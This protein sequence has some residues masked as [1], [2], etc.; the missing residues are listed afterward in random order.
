MK[1]LSLIALSLA[2]YLLYLGVSTKKSAGGPLGNALI[3]GSVLVGGTV[4]TIWILTF[5]KEKNDKK[6]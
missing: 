1:A 6:R 5:I 2:A 4:L 3:V